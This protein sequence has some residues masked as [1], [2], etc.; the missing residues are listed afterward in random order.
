MPLA[1]CARCD[2]LF[3]KVE[4]SICPVCLPDEENDYEKIRAAL[5]DFENLSAEA[6]AEQ[7]DVA[8]PVVIRMLDQGMLTNTALLGGAAKCGRCGAPAISAIK[9]LCYAC[10]GKLNQNIEKEKQRITLAESKD[11]VIGDALIVRQKIEEKREV[12]IQTKK[13]VELDKT[14]NVRQ[15]LEQ[16]RR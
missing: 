11:V 14:S 15:M 6:V 10:I 7:A 9:K 13:E 4:T 8:L 5:L 1:K 3:D 16:K 12:N 2:K